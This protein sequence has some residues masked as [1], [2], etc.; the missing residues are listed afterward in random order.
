MHDG[1]MWTAEEG[2]GPAMI[3]LK[4]TNLWKPVMEKSEGLI[5]Q[6]DFVK[7]LGG[8][9]CQVEMWNSSWPAEPLA[10]RDLLQGWVKAKETEG[11][12]SCTGRQLLCEPKSGALSE[13]QHSAMLTY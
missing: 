10:D 2:C 11:G 8:R 7:H 4:N 9:A 12:A 6:L 3:P 5:R 1:K 13:M